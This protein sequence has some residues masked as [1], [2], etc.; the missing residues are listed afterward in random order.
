[1]KKLRELLVIDGGIT[2][3]D[4]KAGLMIVCSLLVLGG[5]ESVLT[6]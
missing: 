4:I 6:V 5:L 2:A 1:M 3:T